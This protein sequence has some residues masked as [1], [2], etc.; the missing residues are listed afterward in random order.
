MENSDTPGG[1]SGLRLCHAG[2]FSRHK[3]GIHGCPISRAFFA[4][5]VGILILILILILTRKKTDSTMPTKNRGPHNPNPAPRKYQNHRRALRSQLPQPRRLPRIRR[6]QALGRQPPLRLRPRQRRAPLARSG[7]MHRVPARPGLRNP[8][9]LHHRQRT[10][11]LHPRRR[12]FHRRPHSP[13]RHLVHPPSRSLHA[14]PHAPLLPAP[15]NP[16]RQTPRALPR[17]LAPPPIHQRRHISRNPRH[18]RGHLTKPDLA[19]PTPAPNVR[20]FT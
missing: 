17:S 6:R 19:N 4:R 11:R 5:E 8:R 1:A 2:I 7:Q 16:S 3:Q 12:G 14:S 15:R 13:A 20:E 9:H 10:R 18:R